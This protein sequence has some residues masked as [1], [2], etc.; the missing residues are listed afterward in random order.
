MRLDA[1]VASYGPAEGVAASRASRIN[2]FTLGDTLLATC[3]AWLLRF[4]AGAD[5]FVPET[6]IA[7]ITAPAQLGAEA[8][9]AN[10]DGTCWLRLGA[11]DRRILRVAPAGP[12]HW[13]SDELA[14]PMLH[15][16]PVVGLFED[17]QTLWIQGSDSLVTADLTWKS[18][19]PAAPP[20]ARVRRVATANGRARWGDAAGAPPGPIGLAAEAT[21]LRFEFA[22]A[23]FAPD[24]R[25]RPGMQYRTQLAGFEPG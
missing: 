6:R 10:A 14:A 2:F 11:P 8:V 19:P 22:A 9:G 20:V 17:A 25:G 21:S 12:G 24:H 15:D 3:E 13:R 23:V 16:L 5:R 1:P 4:D 7:G 18:A